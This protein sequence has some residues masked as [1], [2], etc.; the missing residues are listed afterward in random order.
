MADKNGDSKER[1]ITEIEADLNARHQR[2]ADTIDTLAHR[3]SPAEIKR[4]GIA[5]VKAKANDAVAHPDGTPRW[6]RFATALAIVGGTAIVLGL[7]R[8][9]FHRG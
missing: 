2:L 7:A 4:R 5:A 6:D 3:V 8:R 1:S 9:A